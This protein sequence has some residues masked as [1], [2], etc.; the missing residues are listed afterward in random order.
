MFSKIVL[1]LEGDDTG[2]DNMNKGA[3]MWDSVRK[4]NVSN[5]FDV[6]SVSDY[7]ARHNNEG[8]DYDD[9]EYLVDGDN[10]VEEVDLGMSN[11]YLNVD[12]DAK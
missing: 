1:R 3:A 10:M 6:D 9:S 4:D 2:E 12:K 8:S 7:D 11:F 5:F